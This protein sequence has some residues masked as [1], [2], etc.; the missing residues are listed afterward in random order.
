MR[1]PRKIRRKQR[2]RSIW[3]CEK[4][5]PEGFITGPPVFLCNIAGS[6]R[7]N[8]DHE[9][10][11]WG[12]A[13]LSALQ[14]IHFTT[15]PDTDNI[16]L[17]AAQSGNCVIMRS[18]VCVL[19]GWKE[20]R[21]MKK[22]QVCGGPVSGGRC[23]LCGMPYRNDNEMYHL[24]ENRRDHYQH[25]SASTRRKMAESEIPLPDRGR[26]GTARTT[27]SSKSSG[28]AGQ[29]NRP[30]TGSGTTIPNVPKSQQ[31]KK[32]TSSAAVLIYLIILLMMFIVGN[33]S[34][35]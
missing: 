33:F 4:Q 20:N 17:I 26:P 35:C 2:L 30:R 29:Y 19:T 28:T 23:R 18:S 10:C 11:S 27:Y 16:I 21:I 32:K 15:F 5:I 24:N 9:Y 3:D 12:R 1:A 8:S 14:R 13:G 7:Q 34:N 25:A 22:C 6:V 31:K